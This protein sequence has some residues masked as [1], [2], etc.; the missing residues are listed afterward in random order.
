M[1]ILGVNESYESDPSTVQSAERAEMNEHKII[2]I[3]TQALECAATAG[4][5]Q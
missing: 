3:Y 5:C 2:Y 1:Q 4:C